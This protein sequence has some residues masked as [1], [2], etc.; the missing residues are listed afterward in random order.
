MTDPPG[1]L[2]AGL[3]G[4]YRLLHE[5]G[6]GGM[7]TVYLAE[8]IKHRR[9]VAIKVLR[10]D[11]A[12]SL[13]PA[14]FLR[15]I[16]I[17]AQ[18]QHPHIL[19]L[20]D[21]GECPRADGSPYLYYVMPFIAGQSLRER[22]NREGEL[23]LSEAVR[24]IQEV[25]DALAHAH[26]HGVVHR[27]IKPDNVMLSGRHALVAD[28]GVAKA[29]SEAT[30]RNTITTLG[31]AVGTPTY[32]SPEQ[33]A[34]D[35]HIDHRSDIYAV[36]VM[37]YELL[38][39]RPPFT[40]ATPQQ[41][42]AAHVTEI[43]DPVTKRRPGIPPI[44]ASAVMR[45]LEKR[46]ADR[47][48]SADEMLAQ[49]EQVSTTTGGVTPVDTQPVS[50]RPG[51]GRFIMLA[52]AAV[53]VVAAAA[54]LSGL[55]LRSAPPISLGSGNQITSDAGLEILPAMAPDGK[56]VAYAAGTSTRMRIFVRPVA[57]GRIIPLTDD[58]TVIQNQ[59]RWSPDGAS[60]LYL[61]NGG[62]F[63]APALGGPARPLIPARPGPGIRAA[64][65]SPDGG[66]VAF[67]R[68]DSLYDFEVAGGAIRAVAGGRQ[69][70]SCAWSPR[71]NAIAC[72]SGNAEFV[73][74]GSNFGNTAPSTVV[75]IP[76]GRVAPVAV[77]DSMRNNQSPAWS[78]D[79]RTLFYVSD[80]Q[81][82][83]DIY[84]L[85][86]TRTFHP[87][88][89]P[90]RL[91][92]GLNAMSIAFTPDGRHL[93]YAVYTARANIWGLPVPRTPPASIS[94]ATA[95]TSGSQVIEGLR[96]TP[97]GQWLIYDSN[98]HGNSDIFRVRTTGGEPERLTSDPADE[99]QPMLSP[100]GTDIAYHALFGSVRQIFTLSLAGGSPIQVAPSA[101]DQRVADWAPDGSALA[102]YDR[103]QLR[104]WLARRRADGGWGPAELRAQRMMWPR[105]TADG[106]NLLGD[107]PDGRVVEV[108]AA[109]GAMDT[110]YS[111]G[112]GSSDPHAEWAAPGADGHT[113][114][115]KS[116]D[117]E[118]GAT[119][120]SL[121][122]RDA[123]PRPLVT[124][125]DPMRPS[126]RV[127]WATDGK[128]IFFAINDRESDIWVVDVS[129]LGTR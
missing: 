118:G 8:D 40:G 55:L 37:A 76:V 94:Q 100:D 6:T 48:Q 88:G 121:P 85:S 98:L 89:A 4:Q 73:Q 51:R 123:T 90:I 79:G 65:W 62:V 35:T 3:S 72:V 49:L 47:W 33:A 59:P 22:I 97:D 71:G 107:T 10:A 101:I 13:G 77:T 64:A 74:L 87:R 112:A 26:A 1:D 70:H 14:R 93:A 42:L 126:Y 11:L 124:F 25:V 127:E 7:A 15:E 120:W 105:W 21:S 56:F 69:L 2:A 83:R 96:V 80:R 29:V 75:V 28:F 114:W 54:F 57:G 115:F 43:P 44:L 104:T 38:A 27:D 32:M 102:W 125:D 91:T 23:P 39:G 61:A 17:A 82:T 66:H 36:G 24:L 19:P 103:D 45:C 117:T 119:L 63:T 52:G 111:P 78:P 12:A 60:I 129:G 128:R 84:Q 34:A 68:G 122:G 110:L 113:L 9:Q 81:G 86:L 95:V 41:V 30:G 53:I 67:V 109:S 31:V 5:L 92:T 18:L 20:L 50:S 108:S 99:F 116:H 106:Q 58:S 16:E 46:A